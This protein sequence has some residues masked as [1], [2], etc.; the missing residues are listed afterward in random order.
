MLREEAEREAHRRNHEDP[1]R[2]RF[3]FYAFD[4]SA[5]MANHAW[6]VAARLRQGPRADR[7]ATAA[8]AAAAGTGAPAS[9]HPDA[10]LLAEPAHEPVAAGAGLD[11]DAGISYGPPE[12]AAVAAGRAGI[13]VRILG[14]VVVVVG[15]AWIAMVVVLAV[16]LAPGDAVTVAIYVAAAA[17]GL[18]AMALG[19]AIRRS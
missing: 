12:P 1:G 10:A 17:L 13:L 8:A 2:E 15:I 16:I 5:G 9:W 19:V 11:H 14:A 7:P 6:D 3:E 18:F 4:E